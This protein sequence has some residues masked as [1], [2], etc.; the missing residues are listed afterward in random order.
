M[1]GGMSG[2]GLIGI[3]VVSVWAFRM[4]GGSGRG[5]GGVTWGSGEL[6]D[7]F[8]GSLGGLTAETSVYKHKKT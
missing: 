1:S 5:L 6:W 2:G 3:R 7:G 8:G 4:F